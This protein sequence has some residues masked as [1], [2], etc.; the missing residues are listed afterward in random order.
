MRHE[1]SLKVAYI[2]WFFFGAF[3]IHRFYLRQTKTGWMML[4]LA[5]A[6]GLSK[7][8]IPFI[9]LLSVWWLIDAALIIGYV[10]AS[11]DHSFMHV[12]E[13]PKVE[14][15]KAAALSTV[16][17]EDIQKLH[18]MNAEYMAFFARGDLDA[19]IAGA[20][21]ALALC[22]SKMGKDHSQVGMIQNNLGEFY[23]RIGNNPQAI[24]ML[25]S[26][27][28][29][30]EQHPDREM[31]PEQAQDTLCHSLNSLAHIYTN[32][33]QTQDAKKIY[34]RII[35]T[36]SNPA[37]PA[38]ANPS[39]AHA[40]KTAINQKNRSE[41][42]N[43]NYAHALNNLAKLYSDKDQHEQAEQLYS[44]AL[45]LLDYLSIEH[46]ELKV[47]ILKNF[48]TRESTLQHYDRAESLYQRAIRIL[49]EHAIRLAEQPTEQETQQE[50]ESLEMPLASNYDELN[51]VYN[52]Q[53]RPQIDEEKR[54]A[55]ALSHNQLQ[56]A[57]CHH[58]L[59]IIYANQNRLEEAEVELSSAAKMR[60]PI[61][62]SND[63]EF[64]T[65]LS[66]LGLIYFKQNKLDKAETVGKHILN[67]RLVAL[68]EDHADTQRAQR[69]LEL[70]Q[71]EISKQS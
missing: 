67:T 24:N 46:T 62:Q 52:D 35:E 70:I 69:N 14:R 10:D 51:I 44:E 11:K 18:E 12:V 2:L 30:Q 27:I 58:G 42:Q 45:A 63:A 16:K 59:G 39:Q 5:T 36:L 68:G 1:K 23:R 15:E 71:T 26:S 47:D 8:Y 64:I 50:E 53:N 34:R 9:V 66:H 37:G 61:C 54:R 49:D 43:I 4:L 17:F 60:K 32:L 48:A 6:V 41:T 29:I 55:D 65:G 31:T 40:N 38:E 20:T 56:I 25:R 28:A 22:E 21:Q 3:G 57:A 19:A 13:E 33:G 7:G